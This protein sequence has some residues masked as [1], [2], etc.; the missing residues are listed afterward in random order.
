MVVRRTGTTVNRKV[1]TS[2]TRLGIELEQALAD[3]LT[4]SRR[5]YEP[6][7]DL[8]DEQAEN[9]AWRRVESVLAPSA[10]P[11]AA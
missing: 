6:T 9:A 7:H 2:Q 3:W 10:T 5:A 4:A 11:A 1:F 8:S